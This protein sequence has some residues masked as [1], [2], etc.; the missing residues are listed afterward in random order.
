MVGWKVSLDIEG[1]D[2]YGV[3]LSTINATRPKALCVTIKSWVQLKDDAVD[4]NRFFQALERKLNL[5]A[6]WLFGERVILEQ[7]I[8][9]WDGGVKKDNARKCY[10][11]ELTFLPNSTERLDKAAETYNGKITS[12]VHYLNSKFEEGRIEP[13]KERHY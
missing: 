8:S 10:T 13:Q 12:F 3:T 9:T 11:V 4:Y 7:T 2:E 1:L 5:K 6:H